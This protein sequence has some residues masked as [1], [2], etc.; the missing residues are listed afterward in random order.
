MRTSR[1]RALL[2]ALLLT[3]LPFLLLARRPAVD[4]PTQSIRVICPWGAGGGTDACLRAF[5]DALSRE[6]GQ[7][8]RVENLP[9]DEGL[10]GHRA[11]ADAPADGYTIGMITFE[12]AT[13]QPSGAGELTWE[14]FDPICRVNTDAAAITVNAQWARANGVTDLADFVNYCKAHPG[15][16]QLGGSSSASVWHIAGYY[17][18]TA[19]GTDLQMVT[20]G[21]G[22]ATAVRSAASGVIQGVTVSPAEA[23]AFLESGHLICLGVMSPQRDPAFPAVPTCAEQGY[24][25]TYL[26]HRGIAAP[27]GLDRQVKARL[28]EACANAIEDPGFVALM[29]RGGQTISYLSSGDYARFLA[30]EAQ[31]VA[32]AMADLG[33]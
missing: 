8:L 2:L 22:A 1:G 32:G 18:M 17:F 3:V 25:V 31:S 6:L 23:R 7:D 30:E 28:E 27:K 10:A 12:L 24:D 15:Q 11:I 4:Y 13:Y 21:D 5:S 20:Y 14:N 19:T 16:V 29:E 33:L 9:R 26:T